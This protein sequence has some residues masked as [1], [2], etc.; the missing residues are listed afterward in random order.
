[1][2]LTTFLGVSVIVLLL[3]VSLAL[4]HRR[5]T[6][7]ARPFF[8]LYLCLALYAVGFALRLTGTQ[9]LIDF[10]Y[11]LTEGSHLFATLVF[12]AALILGQEKYWAES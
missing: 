10:G 2:S 8:I 9:T 11:F 4:F 1:M 5:F 3:M 7:A 6:R 12:T